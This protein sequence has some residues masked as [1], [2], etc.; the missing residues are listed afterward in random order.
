MKEFGSDVPDSVKDTAFEFRLTDK[1]DE[2][3]SKPFSYQVYKLYKKNAEGEWNKDPEAG[4]YATDG[5]GT[6][7]LKAGEKAVFEKVADVSN[8]E[9]KENSNIF[10]KSETE[11]TPA[12]EPD[13]VRTVTVTNTYRPVLYVE[14]K[15]EGVP[16]EIDIEEMNPEFTFRVQTEKEGTLTPL[17]G[18][19]YYYVKEARTDGGIPRIDTAKGNNGVGTTDPEGEFKIHKGDIIAVFPGNTGTKYEVKEVSNESSDDDWICREDTVTGKIPVRGASA[20]I[21]NYYRWR[22]LYLTKRITH[23]TGW[24]NEPFT[25][26]IQKVEKE[27]GNEKVRLL[28]QEEIERL[29]LVMGI[30]LDGEFQEESGGMNDGD[31]NDGDMNVGDMDVGEMMRMRR[32]LGVTESTDKI[33][34]DMTGKF[35]CYCADKTIRIRGLEAGETY[36]I[37]EIVSEGSMYLPEQGTVDVSMSLYGDKKEV[38]ITNDYQ[39]RPLMISKKV[40]SSSGEVEDDAEFTMQIFVNGEPLKGHPYMIQ[41]SDVSGGSTMLPGGS[42]LSQG[43]RQDILL[44]EDGTSLLRQMRGSIVGPGGSEEVPEIPRTDEN[45]RIKLKNGQTAI[46]I[47]AGKLGDEFKVVEE[48]TDGYRQIAPTGDGEGTFAGD[49]AE[50]VFVN[51]RESEGRNLYISKIYEAQNMLYGDIAGEYVEELKEANK[52]ATDTDERGS[53]EVTLTINGEIYTGP[54]GDNKNVTVV[55]QLTGRFYEKQWNGETFTL[56]PWSIVIIPIEDEGEIVYT[57]SESKDDQHQIIEYQGSWLEIS[58]KEPKND[59]PAE[60]TITENPIATIT[61]EVKSVGVSSLVTKQMTEDSSEVPEGAEL[62]WRVEV[63][64][65]VTWQPAEN[66]PYITLE[67]DWSKD[68]LSEA[69]AIPTCDRILKTGPDGRIVLTKNWSEDGIERWPAVYFAE[70]YVGV[71]KYESPDKDDYRVV[72]VMEESDE[73]WGMLK[74]YTTS[75]KGFGN[76]HDD[77]LDLTGFSAGGFM[78]SNENAPIEIAKEMDEDSDDTFTMILK[79]VLSLSSNV[80]YG[81]IRE[82]DI[83]ASEGRA[84][85]S[86]TVYDTATGEAIAERET[87]KNGEIQLKAGQFVRLNLSN[88]LWTVSEEIGHTY[89]LKSLTPESETKLKKLNDNLML[90]NCEPTYT[91]TYRYGLDGNEILE[92]F[93][94]LRKGSLT[95]KLD[96][97]LERPGYKFTGWSPEWQERVTESVTY[98]AQWKK[99]YT[100]IYQDGI[101]G[102]AFAQ[103]THGKIA[104][105]EE[106]PQ[107]SGGKTPTRK[108]Y[109]FDGWNPKWDSTV[110]GDMANKDGEIIY[111]AQWKAKKLYTVKYTDGVDGEIVFGDQVTE[112]C[113]EGDPTPPY[114]DGTNPIRKEYDFW[115]WA[116]TW[117]KTVNGEDANESGEIVYTATWKKN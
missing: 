91:V 81:N 72:E 78:N 61:N 64:N 31:M 24:C 48:K 60:G 105:G 112:N 53:V 13:Y 41:E 86:Y 74:E 3:N 75:K 44:A 84:G 102:S 110:K 95:P 26:Q 51:A 11:D 76:N 32:G 39:M 88:T 70:I 117:N 66:V 23:G 45:G 25:F 55:N 14:K 77:G 115:G 16:E 111:T 59:R 106:T 21:R 98:T 27:N 6:L 99:T 7:E 30:M 18:Q 116:P 8:I 109:I 33:L 69:S 68:T 19:E 113:V 114:G 97:K 34:V 46:L 40:V 80:D 56:D 71:N 36:R 89:K 63:F 87:G 101:G 43:D 15:L 29:E 1:R 85:I 35:T 52:E 83:I 57:L 58:Q 92:E 17:A 104:E 49:A 20:V 73:A 82:E 4:Q 37:T 67:G 38:T 50:V 100:I 42:L 108:G 28:T 94:G 10:W 62:V 79:Q 96:D 2:K 47:D 93:T 54:E 12:K 107:Y 9:V 22:E 65:G 5:S 103:E 90:I